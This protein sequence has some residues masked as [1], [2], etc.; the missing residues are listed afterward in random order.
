M[1]TQRKFLDCPEEQLFMEA[2]L[3]VGNA[4][5]FDIWT[6]QA[7]YSFKGAMHCY[8]EST[9]KGKIFMNL[10]RTHGEAKSRASQLY[11]KWRSWQRQ[12][13]TVAGKVHERRHRG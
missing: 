7:A 8:L 9:T 13:N 4:T 1:G 5:D 6:S 12:R 11:Y 10:V 2:D 3:F